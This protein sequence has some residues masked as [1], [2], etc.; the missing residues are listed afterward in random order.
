MLWEPKITP[1]LKEIIEVPDIMDRTIKLR[2]ATLSVTTPWAALSWII[3]SIIH[4]NRARRTYLRRTPQRCLAI[5]INGQ[6]LNKYII[7][8]L[9]TSLT[10]YKWNALLIG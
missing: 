5:N 6:H 9:K 4:W 7:N 1:Y 10:F 2:Q 8:V 3:V